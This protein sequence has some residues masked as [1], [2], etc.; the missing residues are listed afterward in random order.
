MVNITITKHL[1]GRGLLLAHDFI[2]GGADVVPVHGKLERDFV[3][4]LVA[5]VDFAALKE[6]ESSLVLKAPSV[7]DFILHFLDRHG[8]DLLAFDV[9]IIPWPARVVKGL[10]YEICVKQ[11]PRGF[12]LTKP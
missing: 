7:N 12:G 6:V 9:Y 3:Q 1:R 10:L 11:K 2:N 5:L 8:D 4:E